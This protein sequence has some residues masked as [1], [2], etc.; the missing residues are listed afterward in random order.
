MPINII[1]YFRLWGTLIRLLN[2]ISSTI[3]SLLNSQLFDCFSSLLF[4]IELTPSPINFHFNVIEV[5]ILLMWIGVIKFF[6]LLQNIIHII[7]LLVLL[8]RGSTSRSHTLSIGLVLQD[9]P[10]FY[11]H[12]ETLQPLVSF[13]LGLTSKGKFPLFA[14]KA[15]GKGKFFGTLH[16]S[17]NTVDINLFNILKGVMNLMNG[18]L[19]LKG[20]CLVLVPSLLV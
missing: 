15:K 5:D 2:S 14:F 18:W 7:M 1:P 13:F 19:T 11:E 6:L 10:K 9:F 8:V 3:E 16:I 12:L 17:I 4:F 20:M